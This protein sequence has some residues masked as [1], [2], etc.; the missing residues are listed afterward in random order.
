MCNN[1][2]RF[3][4][5][6]IIIGFNPDVYEVDEDAGIVRL[7]VAVLNGTINEERTIPITLSTA[8]GS[9]QGIPYLSRRVSSHDFMMFLP[10]QLDQTT[11]P[12][13]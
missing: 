9:A 5:T 3:H 1:T 13:Q 4:D 8:D 6:D 2:T 10:F 11:L 7:F 12:Q